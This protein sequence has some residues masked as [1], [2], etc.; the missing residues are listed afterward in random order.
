MIRAVSSADVVRTLIRLSAQAKYAGD[1]LALPHRKGRTLFAR[2]PGISRAKRPG[3]PLTFSMG[4]A[5]WAEGKVPDQ[6]LDEADRAMDS[7]KALHK[8]ASGR[9]PQSSAI[10]E[11]HQA[12][13]V[14]KN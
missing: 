4:I 9:S 3:K 13:P 11:S 12:G 2:S 8:E 5:E 14:A 1:T 7:T 6:M 10:D